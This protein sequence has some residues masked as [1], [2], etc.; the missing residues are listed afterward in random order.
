MTDFK[1]KF[2]AENLSV[3]FLFH[4]NICFFSIKPVPVQNKRPV[5]LEPVILLSTDESPK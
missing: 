1:Q 2:K 3:Q 4:I 5:S